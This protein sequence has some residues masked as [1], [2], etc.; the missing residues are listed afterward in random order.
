MPIDIEDLRK[1]CARGAIRWTEHMAKR[2]LGRGIS[3]NQVENAIQFG[4]IIEQYPN[5]YPYPSCLIMGH[6]KDGIPIH[7]VCGLG[8]EAIWMVTAYYPDPM[9]W[10]EGLKTRRDKT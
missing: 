1:M 5:D 6:D 8:T 3:R 10:E 9:E 2:M 7:V 4:E